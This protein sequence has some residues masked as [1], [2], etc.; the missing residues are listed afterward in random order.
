MEIDIFILHLFNG[1]DSLFLDRFVVALTHGLA[2]VPLY[3]MLAILVI[4]NN[5]TMQQILIIFSCGILGVLLSGV[6][7]DLVIKPI[8]MRPRPCYDPVWSEMVRTVSGYEA[9]GYSFFSSHAANTFSLAIFFSLLVRSRLLS[10]TL[11]FWSLFNAWTRVY[12]GVHWFTDVVTGLL[13]GAIVG[14]AMY[15]FYRY[16]FYKISPK[17]KYVSAQYTSTGYAFFDIDVCVCVVV[18]TFI[19][20]ILRAVMMA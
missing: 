11:I 13:W 20:G 10:I 3:I 17:I 5:K 7:S 4:K 19:Y 16:M 8:V 2:W 15:F 14:V 12:L 6:L 9:K 1:S 18:L